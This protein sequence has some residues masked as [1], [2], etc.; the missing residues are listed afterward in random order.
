MFIVKDMFKYFKQKIT[1]H[2]NLKE[3]WLSTTVFQM[4]LSI[5]KISYNVHWNHPENKLLHQRKKE[6]ENFLFLALELYVNTQV[7]KTKNSRL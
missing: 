4:T 7:N 3:E 2:K 5:H 1:V 6:K